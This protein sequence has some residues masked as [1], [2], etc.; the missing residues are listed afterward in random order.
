MNFKLNQVGSPT[1]TPSYV[2]DPWNNAYGYST[3]DANYLTANPQ[4][5]YPNNGSGSYD[6]WTTAGTTQ[7]NTALPPSNPAYY[8][9]N[10]WICNWQ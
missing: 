3:G 6:L 7:N 9:T 1:A 8:A 5:Q 4:N 2:R 10:A